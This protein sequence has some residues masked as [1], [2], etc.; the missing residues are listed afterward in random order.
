MVA[1]M[2]KI[3]TS[4]TDLDNFGTRYLQFIFST[5]KMFLQ[6]IFFDQ[7]PT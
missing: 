5:D 7:I 6:H 3:F 4:K 1:F 2:I